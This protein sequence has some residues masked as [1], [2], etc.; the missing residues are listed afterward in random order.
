MNQEQM[1]QGAVPAEQRDFAAEA[2]QVRA[3]YP[4]LREFPDEVAMD[5]AGGAGLLQA[6]LNYR[7]RQAELEAEELRRENSVLRQNAETAARAPLRGVAGGG[8]TETKPQGAFL[9]GLRDDMMDY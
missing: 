6:Y 5:A 4:D 2:E 8:E 3:L 1:L 7:E 9:R